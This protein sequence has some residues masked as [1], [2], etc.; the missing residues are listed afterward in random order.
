MNTRKEREENISWAE[1]QLN[2]AGKEIVGPMTKGSKSEPYKWRDKKDY[3]DGAFFDTKTGQHTI[4]FS[5][6]MYKISELSSLTGKYKTRLIRHR[7][8]KEGVELENAVR[9]DME[10]YKKE[11]V[12]IYKEGV[13]GEGLKRIR[14]RE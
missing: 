7:E 1:K 4:K 13:R 2:R 9:E 14:V 11:Y 8:T 6:S 3:E 5:F 12:E 10:Q